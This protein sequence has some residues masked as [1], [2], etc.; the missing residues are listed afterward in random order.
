MGSCSTQGSARLTLPKEGPAFL[1]VNKSMPRGYEETVHAV[2]RY[3][4][5]HCEKSFFYVHLEPTN[6]CNTTC[7]I[8][9]REAMRRTPKMMSW[10]TFAAA[11]RL[12]LPTDIPMISLVGFGEPSLH[13][14]LVDMVYFIR[15]YR[16][17]IFIKMTTNGSRLSNAYLD[18]LY[19]AGLDLLEISV[20]G[21]D[22]ATYQRLMGGLQLEPLLQAIGY[23]N[24]RG[25][26]YLLTTVLTGGQ[27]PIETEAF[28]KE[29]GASHLEIKGLHH[30]GGYVSS[31]L[32][33]NPFGN[34]SC[35]EHNSDSVARPRVD[36]CHK[37][38]MFL[39]VNADGNFIPCVQ[40]INN[41]NILTDI[42]SVKDYEELRQIV[43]RARPTFDIC[44]GCELKQQNLIDYYAHFLVK[45]FPERT[46]KLLQEQR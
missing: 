20:I 17:D 38:Y 42:S 13:C 33:G 18:D 39:H 11:M 15:E 16:P 30:R 24:S 10:D 26:L 7:E 25:F 6:A 8:C 34:Y 12:L 28:W 40:E 35:R 5:T 37:L 19:N 27:N 1:K 9:P 22:A 41:K 43:R 36:A 44:N 29:H 31:K 3:I 21:S 23:L 32:L 4:S 46:S 14:K 45:Y 2:A